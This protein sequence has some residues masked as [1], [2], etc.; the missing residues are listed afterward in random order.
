MAEHTNKINKQCVTIATEPAGI[1]MPRH[2][3]NACKQMRQ[4]TASNK[5][6]IKLNVRCK[7][8]RLGCNVGN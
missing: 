7:W 8:G 5:D 4:M 2:F 6:S 3:R 1:N